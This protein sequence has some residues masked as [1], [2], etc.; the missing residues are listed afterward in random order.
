MN[1]LVAVVISQYSGV[2]LVVNDVIVKC[3][4]V[5]AVSH[6]PLVQQQGLFV[7]T[8]LTN[9]GVSRVRRVRI[10]YH[11]VD[12]D[13]SLASRDESDLLDFSLKQES[14]LTQEVLLTPALQVSVNAHDGTNRVIREAGETALRRI[15]TRRTTSAGNVSRQRERVLRADMALLE[16]LTVDHTVRA[17]IQALASGQ[18]RLTRSA[19]EA[20]GRSLYA[21]ESSRTSLAETARERELTL[22]TADA[23]AS[24]KR[25]GTI[26]TSLAETSLLRTETRAALSTD[27][28]GV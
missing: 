5:V 6:P 23:S 20:T 12:N 16:G 1:F 24:S 27:T 21:A 10:L 14:Q 7:T 19:S 9:L 22:G 18:R 13:G 28:S 4:H 25:R 26:G 15:V 3:L 17:D 11:K 2:D 8:Q